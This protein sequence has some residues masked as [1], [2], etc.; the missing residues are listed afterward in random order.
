MYRV[1]LP[2]QILNKQNMR[3]PFLDF[4]TQGDLKFIVVFIIFSGLALFHFSKKVQS[5]KIKDH[6]HEQNIRNAKI[7]K[8][9][10]WILCSS[11]LSLLLG[12]LHS[13]YFIGQVGNITPKLIFQGTAIA[14]ITPTLG[15]C[16]FIICHILKNIFNTTTN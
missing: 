10:F 3:M 1:V 16:L 8:A 14:L 15:L 5:K 6:I 11:F 7:K 4:I 12:L 13:F 2:S 9:A